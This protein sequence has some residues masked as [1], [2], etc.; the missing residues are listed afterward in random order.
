MEVYTFSLSTLESRKYSSQDKYWDNQNS[1]ST[2]PRA[3]T[4]HYFSAKRIDPYYE[5]YTVY[6]PVY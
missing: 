1:K 6:G 4:L 5:D 3:R 2:F